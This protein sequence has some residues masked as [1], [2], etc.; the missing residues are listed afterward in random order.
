MTDFVADEWME[1]DEVSRIAD[2]MLPD[3]PLRDWQ[4]NL[5][6]TENE[7]G[8]GQSLSIVSAD[9]MLSMRLTFA[10]HMLRDVVEIDPDRAGGAP[11]L[12]G[13]RFKVG[14]ILAELA[15]GMTVSK[16]AR[17][18][19]LDKEKIIEFLR[20]LAIKLDRPFSR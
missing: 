1:K 14:R 8:I 17:E 3:A 20:G 19:D 13:T 12:V 11:V 4:R 15:D 5:S 7:Y 16:L 18:F 2:L 10:A 6:E 9:I